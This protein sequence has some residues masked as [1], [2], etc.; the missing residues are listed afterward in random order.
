MLGIVLEGGG[1]KGAYQ[2]GVWKYLKEREIH[3]D[4]VVGASIGACNGAALIMDDYEM[5]ERVWLNMPDM[6]KNNDTTLDLSNET[7]DFNDMASLEK[8][9]IEKDGLDASQNLQL[10][11][12]VIDEKKIRE[13]GKAFGITTY[14]LTD[15][16]LEELFIE[17][18]P[19]GRLYRYIMASSFLIVFKAFEIEG[20][21]Y[22][23]GGYFNNLP[24]NML[25][26]KGFKTI[27][28][29][30]LRP[31]EFD[32]S[33]YKGVNIIEIKPE[34]SLGGTLQ[35]ESSLIKKNIQLGYLDAK[36]AL[37]GKVLI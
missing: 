17:E 34:E 26:E 37:K 28:S 35:F 10:L 33:A 7:V 15:E 20:K 4:G 21:Y 12:K 18:I 32:Y 8:N 2:L 6:Y 25:V 19:E 23:D 3:F 14:N 29:V 30:R 36:K 24:I 11:K 16:K 9:F 22:L 5:A 31:E 1:A 27:I 13:S